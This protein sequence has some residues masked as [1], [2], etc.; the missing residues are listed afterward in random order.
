MAVF[1]KGQSLV[2]IRFVAG[3]ACHWN[4]EIITQTQWLLLFY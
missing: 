4:Q 2:L 1:V 3:I